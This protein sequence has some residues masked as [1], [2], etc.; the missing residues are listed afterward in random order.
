VVGLVFLAIRY[1]GTKEKKIQLEEVVSSM[2]DKK[3][4]ER[5]VDDM[6]DDDLLAAWLDLV[7]KSSK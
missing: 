2:R 7:R 1:G 6:D 3:V 5:E 4:I